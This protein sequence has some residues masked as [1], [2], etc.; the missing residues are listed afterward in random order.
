MFASEL[1]AGP[2]E[3]PVGYGSYKSAADAGVP[4]YRTQWQIQKDLADELEERKPAAARDVVRLVPATATRADLR[5]VINTH[6]L[7]V[8]SQIG[9]ND[10]RTRAVVVGEMRACVG[11]PAL[12]AA[13]DAHPSAHVA[14]A[15]DSNGLRATGAATE[16]EDEV[17]AR[18]DG[19]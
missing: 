1:W 8:S 16:V 19:R 18:R 5:R 10:S 15:Y 11:L 6:R 9:G 14:D 3:R 12:T 2:P 13:D 4:D 17:H 7:P